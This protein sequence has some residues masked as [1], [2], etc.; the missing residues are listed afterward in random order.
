MARP[1][2]YVIQ[3]DNYRVSEIFKNKH[4]R[5]VYALDVITVAV[6]C[7]IW[8]VFWFLN[9]KAFWGFL[10]ALFFFITEFALYFMEDL[11][12]RKKPLRYTKRTVRCLVFNTLVASGAVA[13][14]FAIAT[15]NLGDMYLR[16]TIFLR[17]YFYIR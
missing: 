9:A 17:L 5:L 3:N 8:L 15:A 4:L 12:D 1:Y 10:I 16:Y 13:V 7:G 14:S 6:F 2:L 11:P